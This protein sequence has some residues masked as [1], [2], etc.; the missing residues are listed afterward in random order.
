MCTSLLCGQYLFH[1][2][3]IHLRDMCTFCSIHV[4]SVMHMTHMLMHHGGIANMM[5][6]NQV[7]ATYYAALVHDFEHLGVNNDYLIKT[8]HPLAVMYNDQSPLENHHL[9]AAVRVMQRPECLYFTVM[10]ASHIPS[11]YTECTCELSVGCHPTDNSQELILKV[12]S[13]RSGCKASP[14]RRNSGGNEL[15]S[16]AS[17]IQML[18]LVYHNRLV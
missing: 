18:L 12:E 8:F 14:V 7:L 5:T 2:R 15:C 4:A 3:A 6:D 1:H 16:T 11:L 9:A 17:M 13:M 10:T